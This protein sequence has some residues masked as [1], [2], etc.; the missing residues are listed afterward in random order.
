M[1]EFLQCS[2][3]NAL[4]FQLVKWYKIIFKEIQL[5]IVKVETLRF[6][7]RAIGYISFFKLSTIPL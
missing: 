6:K 1:F 7:M 4:I 2:R 3:K 5:R